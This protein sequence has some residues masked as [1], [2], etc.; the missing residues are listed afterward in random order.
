[1]ILNQKYIKESKKSKKIFLLKPKE[2]EDDEIINDMEEKSQKYA[3]LVHQVTIKPYHE[4]PILVKS[5]Q[6]ANEPLFAKSYEPAV[7]RFGTVISK[8]I[9]Q[10][11][12]EQ[13]YLMIANLSSKEITLPTGTIIATLESYDEK[14]FEIVEWVGP[15]EPNI[16]KNEQNKNKKYLILEEEYNEYLNWKPKQKCK[17]VLIF[18]N[19]NKLIET[20]QLE[21]QTFETSTGN[22]EIEKK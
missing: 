16:S 2:D 14:E 9:V 12:E 10:F 3:H 6:V 5:N 13:A 17:Q 7:E 1:M 22:K 8:G 19:E 18:N 21:M 20:M 11:K 15:E 4:T